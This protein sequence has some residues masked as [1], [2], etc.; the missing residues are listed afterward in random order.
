M[1]A[2]VTNHHFDFSLLF[3]HSLSLSHSPSSLLSLPQFLP[4]L[5]LTEVSQLIVVGGECKV[6]A[7]AIECENLLLWVRVATLEQCLL[8]DFHHLFLPLSLPLSTSTHVLLKWDLSMC[9]YMRM[10]IHKWNHPPNYYIIRQSESVD[11]ISRD[12]PDTP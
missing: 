4:P 9:I 11:S 10:R 8:H 3:P 1:H 7:I 6:F 12:D 2:S 5:L